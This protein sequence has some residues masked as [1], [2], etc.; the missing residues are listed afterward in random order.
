[1]GF[2]GCRCNRRLEFYFQKVLIKKKKRKHISLILHKFLLYIATMT[3]SLCITT[4]KCKY[5]DFQLRFKAV[6]HLV[7]DL[8]SS[9]VVTYM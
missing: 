5:I 6:M 4:F 9:H 8:C 2:M 1:M 7:W 3:I